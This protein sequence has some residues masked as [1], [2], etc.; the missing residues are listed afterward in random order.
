LN[1]RFSKCLR[2]REIIQEGT[3]KSNQQIHNPFLFV[4]EP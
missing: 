4:T 2:L 1:V 3:N